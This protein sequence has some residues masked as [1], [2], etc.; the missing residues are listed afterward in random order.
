VANLQ[1]FVRQGGVLL[2]VSN[3]AELAIRYGMAPGVSSR[4]G[5]SR[6]TGTLLRSRLV[7]AASPI[8]YGV[9]DSMAILSDDGT[10]YRV[11]N[12]IS[13]GGQSEAES[14]PTGRGRADESD[15]VQGR[16]ALEDRF[17]AAPRPTVQS[18]QA[19]AVTDEQLRNPLNVIPPE[20]R[21]RVVLRFSERKN[22]L[23]SGLLDGGSE[24]AERPVVIDSPI[25]E[26]H[27]VLFGFNPIYRGSTIGAY[28][29]VLNSILN[30]DNLN[31]GRKLDPR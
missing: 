21:P 12:F 5:S 27:V 29:L 1:A 30:F 16:P 20:V 3:T 7:D 26:G 25:G 28:P 9:P 15:E 10:S 22:L 13:G 31:A 18:W 24:I 6:V 8:A 23:V 4:A 2:T 19:A 11:S 14:R 17:K